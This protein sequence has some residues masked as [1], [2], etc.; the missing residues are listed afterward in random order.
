[1]DQ[2]Q[3]DSLPATVIGNE[4]TVAGSNGFH[5]FL[6]CLDRDRPLYDVGK[7]P[8]LTTMGEIARDQNNL[9]YT[10]LHTYECSNLKG[11]DAMDPT[12]PLSDSTEPD[13]DRPLLSREPL[14]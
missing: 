13:E 8:I 6:L 9:A 7:T 4:G 14:A 11:E 10:C 1:M 12:S 5:V 2:D 3:R